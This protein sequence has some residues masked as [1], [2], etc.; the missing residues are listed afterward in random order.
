MRKLTLSDIPKIPVSNQ[1]YQ[2]SALRIKA[3]G[4]DALIFISTREDQPFSGDEKVVIV[5]D[6]PNKEFGESFTTKYFDITEPGILD[7]GY[8]GGKIIVEL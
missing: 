7:W 3:N 4:E 1:D 2:V 6:K 5:W 8:D